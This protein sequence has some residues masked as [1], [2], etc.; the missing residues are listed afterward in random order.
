M[1]LYIVKASSGS[2]DSYHEWIHSIHTD[3]QTAEQE[4]DKINL[5]WANKESLPSPFPIDKDGDLINEDSLSKE[6]KQKYHEWW[7][8]NYEAREWREAEVKE[9]ET[10]K[11]YFKF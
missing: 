10:D 11:I 2:Y 1:I 7:N 4:K 5:E 3:Q 6:D 8:V 9:Y